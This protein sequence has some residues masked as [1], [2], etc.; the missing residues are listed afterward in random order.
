MVEMLEFIWHGIKEGVIKLREVA[1][2]EWICCLKLEK[3]P[4]E[5]FSWKGSDDTHK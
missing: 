2:L 1:V 3:L 4:L 5:C